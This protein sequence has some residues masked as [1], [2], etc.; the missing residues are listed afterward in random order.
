M[1]KYIILGIY[2]LITFVVSQINFIKIGDG[3]RTSSYSRAFMAIINYII[4]T[5]CFYL[6][7]NYIL[8]ILSTLLV[9]PLCIISIRLN[10]IKGFIHGDNIALFKKNILMSLIFIVLIIIFK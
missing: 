10:F 6:F 3:L 9:L 5:I 8:A 4:I 7:G 2:F 1:Y